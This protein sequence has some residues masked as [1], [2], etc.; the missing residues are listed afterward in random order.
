MTFSGLPCARGEFHPAAIVQDVETMA[1][2][3]LAQGAD[4][5][6][7]I[8][9]P[10]SVLKHVPRN[11]LPTPGHNSKPAAKH[12]KPKP[13][14][15]DPEIERLRRV[16]VELVKDIEPFSPELAKKVL[17]QIYPANDVPDD[18]DDRCDDV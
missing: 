10:S 1:L 5:K 2:R 8:K 11:L 16:I 7:R 18:L 15:I 14:P 3:L 12:K 6:L 9:H 4:F 13:K 17:G